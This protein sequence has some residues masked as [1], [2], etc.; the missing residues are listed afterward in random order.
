MNSNQ[1][2][3]YEQRNI[4]RRNKF[5]RMFMRRIYKSLRAFNTQFIPILKERGVEATR[6]AVSKIVIADRIG[7]EIRRLYQ[8][9]GITYATWTYNE[10]Q[11]SAYEPKKS[12]SLCRVRHSLRISRISQKLIGSQIS[13][14]ER[15]AQDI[16]DYFRMYLIDKAVVPITIES[17]ARIMAI[18][19]TG[20]REGWTIERMAKE[21]ETDQMLMWRARLIVRTETAKA[22]YY[23]RR[24]GAQD[25]GFE[26]QREWVAA[27]DSRT[28]HS[29]RDVDGETVDFNTKFRVP[30]YRR[31]AI[32]GYEM[33]R[34]PGDPEASAENV[35]NCRC[36]EAYSAK[37]DTNGRLI[38]KPSTRISVIQPGNF[39]RPITTITV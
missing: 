12:L 30:I 15:W 6:A 21:L 18:L 13:F 38:R 1:R 9:V 14:N 22:A 34:G 17:K 33:L 23:G 10:I 4:I 28:R 37:R 8:V 27:K 32:I 31:G 20:S 11:R 16:L 36:T 7:D 25:S 19:D 24:V 39:N 26:T 2:R 35:C 3:I 29:H 5:E